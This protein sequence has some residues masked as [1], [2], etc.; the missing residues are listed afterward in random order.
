MATF[1]VSEVERARQPLAEVAVGDAIA[2]RIAAPGKR[3]ALEAWGGPHALVDVPGFEQRAHGLIEAVHTAFDN[4][5]PL[6]LSPDDIWLC[7]AQ[8]FAKHVELNA[9]AL[10]AQ[11]VGHDDKLTLTVIRDGFVKGSPDNDWQGCFAEWSGAIAEHIGKKRDLIVSAFSTTGPIELAASE[12]VLMDAMKSYFNYLLV[13]RCGIPEIEL[14]GTVEDWQSIRRR[15]E[16]FAE[17]GLADWVTALVPVLDQLVAAAAGKPD[18][19]FWQSLYKRNDHSGGPYVTGW[20]NVLFPYLDLPGQARSTRNPAAYAWS[21]DHHGTALHSFPS[22]VS[23]VPLRWLYLGTPLQMH[24]HAGFVGVTQA[25]DTGAVRP[26]IGW[27]VSED[28]SA[29]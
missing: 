27:A 13:T 28:E 25:G 7:I 23:R 20:I 18:T 1:R 9:E 16:V 4:H 24:L 3:G 26:A 15:A 2:Q 17:F 8:A 12:I 11:L 29:A 10:R 22:G 19:A 21:A 14:L 6:A 5:H